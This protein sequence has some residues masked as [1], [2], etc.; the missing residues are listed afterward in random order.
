MGLLKLGS[1]E[2]G[3][4][5]GHHGRGDGVISFTCSVQV[6][7]VPQGARRISPT[8]GRG[9]AGLIEKE[10]NE[11]RTS[12]TERPTSNN[13]FCLFKKRQSKENPY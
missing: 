10:T 6:S 4:G 7:S 9:A 2:A 13:V 5:F 11:H 3:P 1:K 8:D 12:N